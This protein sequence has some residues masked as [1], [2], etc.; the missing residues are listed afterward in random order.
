MYIIHVA[1]YVIQPFVLPGLLPDLVNNSVIHGLIVA[2]FGLS[3]HT[4]YIELFY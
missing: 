1:V 3:I 4:G 2:H